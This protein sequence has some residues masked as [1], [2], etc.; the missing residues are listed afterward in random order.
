MCYNDPD[1][2]KCPIII[3]IAIIAA[4]TATLRSYCETPWQ[5]SETV[6]E[7]SDEIS[8]LV[9]STGSVVR[10]D[11]CM[12]YNPALVVK[13]TPKGITETGGLQ[14]VGDVY[15][16]IETDGLKRGQCEIMTRFNREKPTVELWNTSTDRRAAFSPNWKRTLSKLSAS[17][18]LI[19]RYETTLGHIRTATFDVT[20]LTNSLK[21]VKSRYLSQVKK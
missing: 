21:Q 19:V 11:D 1:D 8:Y 18:N 5:I 20:H 7:M 12:S 13:V 2:M 4:T 17:T 9:H 16:S 10:L 6:D 14:Y 15:L 3:A